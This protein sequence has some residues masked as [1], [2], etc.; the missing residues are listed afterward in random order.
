MAAKTFETA[1]PAGP[2]ELVVSGMTCGSCANRVQRVL[3][4][5]EG[6]NDAAVNFAT[7]RAKVHLDRAKVG[8]T[9]DNRRTA[10]SIAAQ[11]GIGRVLAEVG[12][13]DRLPTGGR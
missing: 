2:V 8:I 5:H 7:G 9:G 13:G 6:V 4:R 10:E 1:A 3:S 12:R 11:A